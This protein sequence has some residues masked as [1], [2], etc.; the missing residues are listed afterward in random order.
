MKTKIFSI[1]LGVGALLL[2]TNAAK[3]QIQSEQNV[4]MTMDLQPVLQLNMTTPDEVDFT[5]DNIAAYSGGLIKYGATTLTVS[6]TVDWSLYAVGYSTT[7]GLGTASVWDNP[8]D[9]GTIYTSGT[10]NISLGVLELHQTG[11]NTST[12]YIAGTCPGTGPDYSL[13]FQAVSANAILVPGQNNIFFEPIGTSPYVAPASGHKYI[14]GGPP[15]TVGDGLAGG[16]YLTQ[17]TFPS[18]YYY[19]IDYRIVPGLPTIFP[20]N[21]GGAGED[22]CATTDP[23]AII[24]PLFAQPGFYTMDVKY[25]LIESD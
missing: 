20:S 9:Y 6:S 10:T 17:A 25:L 19:T 1:V 11:S 24:S 8:L 2:G 7:A 23:A 21:Q 12:T 14:A 13:P 15:T 22:D 4:T 18:A 16:S 3:A 5:F